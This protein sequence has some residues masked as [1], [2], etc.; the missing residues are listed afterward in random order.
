MRA[1]DIRLTEH[2]SLLEF[3]CPCCCAV[4][5]HPMLLARLEALR[6]KWGGAIIVNSGY[7]CE[8]HNKKVGGVANS[9]HRLGR[10]ADVRVKE[11]DQERFVALAK[12]CGFSKAIRY[13][14]RGFVHLESG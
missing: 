7:R 14:R 5:L 4:M 12:K 9:L 6:V 13:S 1:N 2:F 10:A 3:Q 8:K 11:S